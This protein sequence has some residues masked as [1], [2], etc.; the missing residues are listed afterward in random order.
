[1]KICQVVA[2]WGEGGL[3]KHVLEVICGLQ[4]AGHE[5]S[6]IGH[7]DWA[8]KLPAGVTL[9]PADF[10]LPRFSF[11][12][13]RTLLRVFRYQRFDVVHAQANKAAS[14]VSML[15]WFMAGSPVFV[16]TL[17][18]Q[19]KRLSMFRGFDRVIA[20]SAQLAALLP[21]LPVTVIYNSVVTPSKR[22]SRE[23][24]L[25]LAGFPDDLP[26][27]CSVG[28]LVRAKGFDLL[29]EAWKGVPARLMIIGE[30]EDRLDL[31]Q[32]IAAYEFQDRICLT[33]YRPDAAA[34]M[35]GCD[36]LVISSRNEGG[37]YTL[38]EAVLAGISVVAT[39]VGIV[40]EFLPEQLIVPVENIKGLNERLIWA[41]TNAVAW[42]LAMEPVRRHAELTLTTERMITA[43]I[44]VYTALLSDRG[45]ATGRPG[46]R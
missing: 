7:P 4:A 38:G 32:R 23:Q 18:N 5:V 42:T 46:G 34:V 20:V 45:S 1:M 25:A 28:R 19:K 21:D 40:R 41:S 9:Y 31:E 14:L 2:S 22:Y 36:G 33:G 17:H 3:E 11:T 12:L 44:G 13:L 30:G 6:L 37:P 39:D 27:F 15:K 8:A 26:V 35:A 16:A 10:E 24:S 43:I 29:V